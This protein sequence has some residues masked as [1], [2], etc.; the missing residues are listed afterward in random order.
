MVGMTVGTE[1][2]DRLIYYH[3]LSAVTKVQFSG[4]CYFI[5]GCSPAPPR[6][7]QKS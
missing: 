1:V 2:Q 5:T 7:Q 3:I 6:V 4:D